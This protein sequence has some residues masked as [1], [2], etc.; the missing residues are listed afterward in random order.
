M[1][2][3]ELVQAY[4]SLYRSGLRAVQYSKPARYVVRNQL[5]AAFR[6]SKAGPGAFDARAIRNTVY[7]L[8]AAAES[9]ELEHRIVRNLVTTAYWRDRR[10]A[11]QRPSWSNVV[12]SKKEK[13]VDEID[14]TAYDHYDQTVKQLN[15]TMRMCL[16][17]QR[18]SPRAPA[19]RSRSM[20]AETDSGRDGAAVV[21]RSHAHPRRWVKRYR[22]E[23][24][25]SMSSVLSTACAFPLDS[26]KTRMQTYGYG[27]FVDCV[28][29][30]YRTEGV[31]GFFRGV[32]APMAS[33]TI[34]RTISF[35]IYQR[36]KYVYGDWIRRNVGYDVHGHVSQAGSY[37]SLWTVACFGAAGATAGSCITAIACPFEL[38]K[39]SAQI[40]VLMSEKA[41]CPD[42]KSYAV[43]SS[44]QNK[45]TLKTMANIVRHRGLSGLYTG[46]RLHLLRDTLGTGLYF[47]TYESSKQL[48]TTV[49]GDASPSNPVSVFVAGGLCGVVSWALIYPID[50]AKS[51]YQRNALMH[52]KGEHIEPAK[53][54]F[55]RKN[56]YRG[57]GVSMTR[58]CLVNAIFFSAFEFWKKHIDALE[59]HAGW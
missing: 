54:S 55:F 49:V 23:V 7:F 41:Q 13:P 46:F 30:T 18:N 40:S 8:N 43:A 33:V 56:M 38:T 6:D 44:Y 12:A 5:R 26:V 11:Q 31:G 32:T 45:G 39:L 10:A 21:A 25:A 35:S 9:R 24:S 28:R 51:I 4:R 16:R 52:A 36:A 15:A 50:S 34:V 48:M 20:P 47:M 27:G 37:P 58:S 19:S 22:T 17:V 42:P 2:S 1:S 53:V 3:A 57:L 29:R 59:D 14:R